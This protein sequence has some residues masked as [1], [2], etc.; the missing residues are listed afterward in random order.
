MARDLN[1]R[2]KKCRRAGE[3]LF[4]KGERCDTPKCGIVRKNYAPGLHG[5]KFA[6][7]LSEY[8]KQLAMK[9]KIK[10]IYGVMEKQFR[11]HFEEVENKE[12]VVG[13]MLMARLEMRL[14]NVVYRIGFANSRSQARQLV[15]HGE[16][17]V[18]GK[19]VDIPSYEVKIDD[20]VSVRESKKEKV[21]FKEQGKVLKNR[22]NFPAWIQFDAAKLEGK[23]ISI[24]TRD[25]ME[26]SV[27][28]QLVVEAYSR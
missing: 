18:N 4:L 27:D 21:F 6:R 3:K 2:C 11:K 1:A 20:V 26:I 17:T 24:P 8:G 13:D 23:V 7:G 28:T 25:D 10:R 15:N 19:K 12:G 9:Q 5:K 14:D 22:K 16:M